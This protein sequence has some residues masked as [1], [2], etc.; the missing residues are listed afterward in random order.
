MNPLLRSHLS[1]L[2]SE[3]SAYNVIRRLGLL[4]SHSIYIYSKPPKTRQQMLSDL[5]D[6]WLI[7]SDQSCIPLRACKTISSAVAKNKSVFV[8]ANFGYIDSQS[9]VG[10]S[11]RYSPTRGTCEVTTFGSSGSAS[12]SEEDP[13]EAAQTLHFPK[14]RICPVFLRCMVSLGITRLIPH[15]VAHSSIANAT[16]T[17]QAFAL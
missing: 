9:G 5:P 6:H 2:Y 4:V 13:L 12:G 17:S 3:S 8:G 10:G 14:T 15:V 16:L 11:C 7:L 1:G